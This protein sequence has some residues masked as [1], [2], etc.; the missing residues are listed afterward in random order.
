MQQFYK[1]ILD[2][3]PATSVLEIYSPKTNISDEMNTT[4]M[5]QF[6]DS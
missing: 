6:S 1:Q 4:A 3:V 5:A 2:V